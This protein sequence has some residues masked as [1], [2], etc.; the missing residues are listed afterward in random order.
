MRVC[1]VRGAGGVLVLIG[2]GRENRMEGG[3]DVWDGVT[4]KAVG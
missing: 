3:L 1:S 2:L 4:A